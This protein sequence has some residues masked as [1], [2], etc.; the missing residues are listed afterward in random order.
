VWDVQACARAGV[1]C[2]AL[3][4]GGTSAAELRDAGAV[5]VYADPADLLAHWDD[6]P[7]RRR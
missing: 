6:S 1:E 4:C 7:L 2:V 3:E 5:A